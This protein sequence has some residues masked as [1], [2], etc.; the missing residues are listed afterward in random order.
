MP[1]PPIV[2][3]PC[4]APRPSTCCSLCLNRTP[5]PSPALPHLYNCPRC[6]LRGS[7][8]GSAGCFGDLLHT[9]CRQ[10]T[11]QR[12]V[13]GADLPLSLHGLCWT[14]LCTQCQAG[15]SLRVGENDGGKGC[16]FL[17]SSYSTAQKVYVSKE[18]KRGP[19]FSTFSV[20]HGDV[21]EV[22][23]AWCPVQGEMDLAL[24]ELQT[25]LSHS[26]VGLQKPLMLPNRVTILLLGR[27][28]PRSNS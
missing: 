6:P 5:L 21:P 25:T 24:G 10:L 17:G 28:P 15:P 16:F 7:F 14:R 8:L 19:A 18:G 3:F 23:W 11:G 2:Y 22:H 4:L 27:L 9:L 1:I 12:G 20:T 26:A 13:V